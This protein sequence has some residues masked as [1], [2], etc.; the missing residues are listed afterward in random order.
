MEEGNLFFLIVIVLILIGFLILSVLLLFSVSQKRIL[1][2]VSKAQQREIEFAETLLKNSIETQENERTRIARELHDGITS[3]LNVINL[4]FNLLKG[5]NGDTQKEEAIFRD[6]KQSITESINLSREIAH[7]LIPPAF[8]KFGIQPAIEDIWLKINRI[9]NLSMQ[10]DINHEWDAL[11]KME[12][13]HIFRIIQELVNNTLKHAE[14]NNINLQSEIEGNCI[15]ISYSDDGKG[16]VQRPDQ[17]DGIGLKNI[18]ARL[19]LLN[20]E[21]L[22]LGNED[23]KGYLFKIKIPIKTVQDDRR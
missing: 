4:N 16:F 8:S 20:G 14:A 19:K 12:L 13:L 23:L 10:L 21:I 5:N 1:K 22:P 11:P 9:D 17:K 2:E 7:N 15:L 6:I 18:K 3:K